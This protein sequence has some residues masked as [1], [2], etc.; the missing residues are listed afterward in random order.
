MSGIESCD[1]EALKRGSETR[2]THLE[3]ITLRKDD[4]LLV[5]GRPTEIN[6]LG[7]VVTAG[8][9]IDI[10]NHTPGSYDIEEGH[11]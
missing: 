11:G 6:T 8:G 10:D 9:L 1:I 3:T 7:N 4:I 5:Q 2:R